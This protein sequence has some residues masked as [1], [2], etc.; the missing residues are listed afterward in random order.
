MASRGDSGTM[1]GEDS[2]DSDEGVGSG[3]GDCIVICVEASEDR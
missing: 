1:Q 2:I 3:V